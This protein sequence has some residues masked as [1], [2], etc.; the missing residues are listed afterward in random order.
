MH[1]TI[2][3][4]LSS[5]EGDGPIRCFWP[6]R[7]KQNAQ[8]FRRLFSGKIVYAVKCNPDPIVLEALKSGGIND[9][10][11]ASIG[12][13]EFVRSW[14]PHSTLYFQHPV[15]SRSS[16]ISAY[17]KHGVRHF[18]VDHSDE[19]DKLFSELPADPETVVYVRLATP[20]LGAKEDLS[21]KFGATLKE[22]SQLLKSI[23]SGGFTPAL[24]FHV[25]SQCYHPEAYTVA[26]NI[27]KKVLLSSKVR[28]RFLDIGGGF[29]VCYSGDSVA[30]L[31]SFLKEIKVSLGSLPPDNN[32]EVFCEPGRSLVSD[33]MSVL[34]RVC[35]RKE[36]RLYIND[37]IFGHFLESHFH[38]FQPPSRA[39]RLESVLSPHSESFEVCGATCDGN[40]VLPG[41]IKLPKDIQEGDW[42]EFCSMGAYSSALSTGFNGFS[43]EA[44]VTL[45]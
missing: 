25:G 37:G 30:P 3:S 39:I 38:G 9:F 23:D 31:E 1:S 21:K 16:I 26:L 14:N 45:Y 5:Y 17:K 2:D 24:S 15:K 12:E 7:I 27:V 32:R 11:V 8:K 44:S 18:S 19:L 36:N 43:A 33:G 22:A 35:L 41:I 29:P 28:I 13:I 42:I 40:D 10:D 6:Q 20:N 34:V 4:I